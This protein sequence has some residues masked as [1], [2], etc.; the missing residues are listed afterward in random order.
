MWTVITFLETIS[1][2]THRQTTLLLQTADGDELIIPGAILSLSFSHFMFANFYSIHVSGFT[3][4]FKGLAVSFRWWLSRTASL[5]M[6]LLLLKIYQ[7]GIS[8]NFLGFW[9]LWH[10]VVVNISGEGK[11]GGQILPSITTWDVIPVS[12]INCSSI[13]PHTDNCELQAPTALCPWMVVCKVM[14]SHHPF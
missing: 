12:N 14:H 4:V 13:L 1:S 2:K 3:T 7:F 11:G 6:R 5:E 10:A 9:F 8:G